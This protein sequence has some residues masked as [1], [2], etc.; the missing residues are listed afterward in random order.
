MVIRLSNYKNTSCHADFEASFHR[1]STK[2][3]LSYDNFLK[4]YPRPLSLIDSFGANHTESLLF[5]VIQSTTASFLPCSNRRRQRQLAHCQVPL[6]TCRQPTLLLKMLSFRRTQL[7]ALCLGA[8]S[9]LPATTTAAADDVVSL[10]DAR[11]ACANIQTD[12]M[13]DFHIC[14]DDVL[15][16][17]DVTIAIRAWPQLLDNDSVWYRARM[18]CV[19]VVPR[20]PS[21]NPYPGITGTNFD[22]CVEEIV[23]SGGDESLAALWIVDAQ[24]ETEDQHL[25]RGSAAQK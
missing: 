17:G 25:R 5:S 3:I 18:A 15:S 4:K 2:Y 8:L 7:G 22:M 10:R 14:V 20:L 9:S 16:T 13:E 12:L 6:P 11:I 1:I 21:L 24:Q 19:T 23:Y